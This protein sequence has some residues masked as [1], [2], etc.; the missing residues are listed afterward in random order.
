VPS[1]PTCREIKCDATH[2]AN[3]I[4]P[5]IRMPELGHPQIEGPASVATIIEKLADSIA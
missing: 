2:R 4:V 5:V 3:P 1:E